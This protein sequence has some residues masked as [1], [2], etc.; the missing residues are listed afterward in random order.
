MVLKWHLPLQKNISLASVEID[1]ISWIFIWNLHILQQIEIGKCL[2]GRKIG[3]IGVK[4]GCSSTPNMYFPE[5][6]CEWLFMVIFSS[7]DL[8]CIAC[9]SV[10]SGIWWLNQVQGLD[11]RSIR[12]SPMSRPRYGVF[13]GV[14]GLK[15]GV[16]MCFTGVNL[17]A[18]LTDGNEETSWTWWTCSKPEK[19]ET[20]SAKN[21]LAR[22]K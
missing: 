4:W 15:Y 11:L 18:C 1:G 19:G 12:Q 7:W 13:T 20:P 16:A 14:N 5:I 2:K 17:M 3:I 8:P 22:L 21:V 10:P 9:G 6:G